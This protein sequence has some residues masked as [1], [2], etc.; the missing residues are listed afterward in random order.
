MAYVALIGDMVG[1]RSYE[2]EARDEIQAKLRKAL[3]DANSD[4]DHRGDVAAEFVITTGDEFQGL[5]RLG[6]DPLWFARSIQDAMGDKPHLRFGMGKGSL[7]TKGMPKQAIGIDGP[8]FHNARDAITRA[9]K[10]GATC[11]V[12][13]FGALNNVTNV[14]MDNFYAQYW[15]LTDRQRRV[16]DLYFLRGL[17]VD[18]IRERFKYR[19][20]RYV[21]KILEKRVVGLMRETEKT[22][23]EIFT[24]PVN[25]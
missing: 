17:D 1:S 7:A 12:Q 24:A 2:A 8:C 3:A 11:R 4:E 13:G 16:Y 23:T 20:P 14:L 6:A 19:T 5:L 15:G 21:Y 22:I 25:K 9:K 10:E 18:A